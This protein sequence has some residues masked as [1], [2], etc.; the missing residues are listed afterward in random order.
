MI[1]YS[2]TPIIQGGDVMKLS[3]EVLK[4]HIDIVILSY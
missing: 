2:S 3:K 4:G 1:L